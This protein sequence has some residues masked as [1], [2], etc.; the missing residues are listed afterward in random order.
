[1]ECFGLQ[2]VREAAA[3]YAQMMA[4]VLHTDVEIVDDTLTRV[5][6]TGVLR[7]NLRLVSDGVVYRQIFQ[8]GQTAVIHNPRKNEF[9]VACTN[10]DR[11]LEK[12]EICFPISFE[13]KVVGAVGLVCST[14]LEKNA[15]MENIRSNL[16]FM[17]HVCDMLGVKLQEARNVI[18]LEEENAALHAEIERCKKEGYKSDISTLEELELSE[19]GKALNRFGRDTKG[20][21]MAANA[22][23]IGMA[24]LYRKL[25]SI[26][27]EL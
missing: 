6:G 15:L 11:C 9:C 19:I 8:T 22:L 25:G 18:R 3:A 10:R 7:D 12:M 2:S 5:T 1:M 26:P 21:K 17:G 27:N 14:N 23:G 4:E 20:K 16:L 13:D 24:T